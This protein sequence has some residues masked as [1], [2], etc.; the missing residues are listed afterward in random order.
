MV[1]FYGWMEFNCLKARAITRRQFKT[2]KKEA[3]EEK[4]QNW[5]SFTEHISDLT[6]RKKIYMSKYVCSNVWLKIKKVFNWKEFTADR[7]NPGW[8]LNPGHLFRYETTRPPRCRYC[9]YSFHEQIS[10]CLCDI[11]EN[12]LLKI[13]YYF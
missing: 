12:L 1:S 6:F 7:T 11:Y 5:Y 10:E 13:Y 3:I 9:Q 4:L 2:Q 8:E